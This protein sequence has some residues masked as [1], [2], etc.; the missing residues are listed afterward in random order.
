MEE[1]SFDCENN[2]GDFT[3]DDVYVKQ[4]VEPLMKKQDLKRFIL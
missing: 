3:I 1:I 2:K 4:R